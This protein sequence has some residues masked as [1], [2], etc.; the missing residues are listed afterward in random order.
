MSIVEIFVNS[1]LYYSDYTAIR[2]TLIPITPARHTYNLPDYASIDN[3][4][5][6]YSILFHVHDEYM[7]EKSRTRVLVSYN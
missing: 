1:L 7:C 3:Y 6:E 5:I 2:G 4:C